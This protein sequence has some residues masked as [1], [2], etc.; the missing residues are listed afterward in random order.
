MGT[1]VVCVISF[2]DVMAVTDSLNDIMYFP[3]NTHIT[4]T[5]TKFVYIIV[6]RIIRSM[7]NRKIYR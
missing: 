6:F 3:L 2:V 1:L 5:G 4:G 7:L